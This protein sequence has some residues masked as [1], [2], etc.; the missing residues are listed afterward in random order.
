MPD[1]VGAGAT[2]ETDKKVVAYRIDRARRL[3]VITY[4][5]EITVEDIVAI[6]DLS[7]RDPMFDRTYAVLFDAL[8]ADL[9]RVSLD[10]LKRI[11]RNTP[12][13][14][15]APRAFVVRPGI[16]YGIARQFAAMSE[17]GGR[18]FSM[19]LFDNMRDALRWLNGDSA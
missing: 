15:G 4:I 13:A 7:R 19:G 18:G 11:A 12:M 2:I 1:V 14:P 17:I 16:G 5:G 9:R 10:G 8:R 3:V 6:Q